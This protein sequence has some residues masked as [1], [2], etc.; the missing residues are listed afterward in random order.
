MAFFKIENVKV[1]GI[2]ACVPKQ[3][4][5]NSAFPLFN[6]ETYTKYAATTGV[7]RKRKA[8]ANMSTSDLCVPAA[9]ALIEALRWNKEDIS[10][11]IL[12][13]QTPDYILPATS[14]LIQHRL[15]LNK[16]CYTLD[17]SLGCSGWVYGMSVAAGLVAAFKNTAGCGKAILLTAETHLKCC[18]SEDQS[19]YPLFGDAAAA[20]AL[21]YEP[22]TDSLFFNMNSDGSGHKAIMINDGGS[23]NPFS[24]ASLDKIVRGNGIISN[25]MQLTLDGMEVFSFGIKRAPECVN[26]LIDEF[27]LDKDKIDYF[28][29]HQANLMMNEQIRKKLK[30]P[31]EKIPYSLKNFGNTASASIPLTMATQLAGELETK[32]LSH[33]ACGFGV[34][35]SWGGIYFATDHIICPSLGEL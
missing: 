19:T 13:S 26:A 1:S 7:E 3:I 17:I 2:S 31:V 30:L 33:I 15:G 20:T 29:F 11:L 32:K 25:N 23:R 21:E 8:P 27:N 12:V 14:P 10:I 22:E 18:S 16:A 4:E 35:L 5:E 28:T 6:S 34:G 9:E 24:V